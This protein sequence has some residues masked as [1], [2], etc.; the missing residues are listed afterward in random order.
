MKKKSLFGINVKL[1]LMLVA[2]CGMFA[3]CYEKEELTT[4]APSTVKPVYKITGVVSNASTGEPLSGAKVN[5]A[6]TATDGTYALDATE[7]LNVLTVTKDDYKTV[8]TSVYVEKI[9]NGKTAVYTVNAAMYP[10]Y[11]TPT[12]KT[13][14]YTIKGT[15]TD[16]SS[17]AVKLSSVVIPGCTIAVVNNTF[18]VEGVQPGTYYAVLKAEGYKNAYAT[19]AVAPVAAEE[20]EGD[21]IVTSTVAVLMQKEETAKVSKYYVC[22]FVTNEKDAAV[23][24]A[25]VKVE[26]GE[27]KADL[28]TDNRGYF[29]I[30]VAAEHITP[31]TLAIITV[32]KAG[33][34]AQA[35]ATVVK[36]VE[37]GAT[38][39]TSIEVVL[40]AES[41]DIPDEDP[42][43]GG[44]Q[45]IEVPVDKAEPTKAEDIKEPE[46]K[47]DIEKV[48]EELGIEDITKIDI[49]VVKV[50]E[51]LV[52]ELVS[53]EAV[54]DETTGETT[55][56]TK[57]VADQIT[58]PANTQVYYVGGQA[59]A[60]KLTRDIQT[61]KATA[62]V[63]TYEGQP[64]GTVF[65][66][67][68]E[69]KFQAP[70]TV[71]VEPD[72]VLGVLY[73][74][75]KTG[76]WSA[77]ANNYAEY[78]M[79]SGTF[80]GKINHFSKFRFG[81][82]SAIVPVDSV[83]LDAEIINKPCYTGSAAAVVTVK[84]NYMGGTAYDGNT[85][86]LA[87]ETALSGM[88][89]ETKSY[90]TMLLKN[91]I[92]KDNANIAP[93]NSYSKTALSVD[94][95]VPAYKQ[96]D[97]FSMVRKQVRRSYTVHVIDKNKKTTDVTVVVKKIIS[98]TLTANYAIGH[99][100]GHG[101]GEDLNAG[102]GIIDFE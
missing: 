96:I 51:A 40:K 54:I 41:S 102:G 65:S 50:E 11:D 1:A 77:D 14:K 58:L 74:N 90:V 37:T 75:E 22:G 94:I 98:T 46:V 10:G 18:T 56:E 20:G 42:S 6:T 48:A 67:P 100:H 57:T 85:P 95:S 93:K 27:F 49:P 3:S 73:Q 29:N 36:L 19:I 21:Q 70:V 17:A 7:G 63:R 72:Y 5:G 80:V 47:A 99:T 52:V 101:N 38:S 60:I 71:T 16:E 55:Q 26:V 12:Y 30:E 43:K 33:Y 91:M 45:I 2:I 23:P 79:T 24:D 15:A 68:L 66:Q 25:T 87:V 34:V 62:A 35:K 88:N 39:V 82:E 81:F 4:E 44:E 97:N 64:S 9:E 13:V 86:A 76:V 53:T 84:G 8:T 78:D 69:V 59:Q 92:L 89:A 31:T 83:K 28:T 61:E 32:S